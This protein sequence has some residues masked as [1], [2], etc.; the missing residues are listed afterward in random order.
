[1]FFALS[2]YTNLA[3]SQTQQQEPKKYLWV[4]VAKIKPD[5]FDEFYKIYTSKVKPAID[6]V[7]FAKWYGYTSF[8]SNRYTLVWMRPFDKL[9]DLDAKRST[10]YK[11]LVHQYGQEVT[12]KIEKVL[13]EV[14]AHSYDVI[15]QFDPNL[16]FIEK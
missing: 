4:N 10:V 15:L 1:M 9:G 6:D 16:S 5:K 11:I 8:V 7:N 2:I 13:A 3:I 12:K 14:T